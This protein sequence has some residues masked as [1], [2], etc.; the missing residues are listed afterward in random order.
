MSRMLNK[1][2]SLN[3]AVELPWADA[4]HGF[5]SGPVVDH[6][7]AD[8]PLAKL[9]VAR[10]VPPVPAHGIELF[11]VNRVDTVIGVIAV[12]ENCDQIE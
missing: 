2:L 11:V 8:D 4:N 6:T 7:E 1:S 9:F 12:A 10:A 5:Q 3:R